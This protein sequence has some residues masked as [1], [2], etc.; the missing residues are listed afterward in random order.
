MYIPKLPIIVSIAI[1]N[2]CNLR[3]KHCALSSGEKL[4]NE[5]TNKEIFRV[6][7][8]M[9]S[10]KIPCLEITGGEPLVHEKIFNFIK[11]AKSKGLNVNL[12][13]MEP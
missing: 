3:C 7:D 6:I 2:R 1:T 4:K 10:K 13:T 11:Y 9:F 8:Y 5:L 12:S